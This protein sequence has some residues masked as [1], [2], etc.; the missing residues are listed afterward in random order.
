[1]ATRR[2]KLPPLAAWI[3]RN[4]RL[5]E[6]TAAKPGRIVLHPYPPPKPEAA[7]GAAGGPRR[8][9]KRGPAPEGERRGGAPRGAALPKESDLKTTVRRLALRLPL[10]CEGKGISPSKREKTRAHPAP[11]QEYGRRSVG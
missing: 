9:R 6:G 11:T 3:E 5:P 10:L 4:V 2:K 1:M 7:S 8:F